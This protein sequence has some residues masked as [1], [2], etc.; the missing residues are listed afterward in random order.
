MATAGHSTTLPPLGGSDGRRVVGSRWSALALGTVASFALLVFMEWLFQVTKPSFLSAMSPGQKA[1]VLGAST[2]VAALWGCCALFPIQV[3]TWILRGERARK[4]ATAAARVPASLALGAL[5]F[6]LVDNFTYTVLGWGV[7]STS[8]FAQRSAYLMLLAGLLAGSYRLVGKWTR[9]ARR[10]ARAWSW[11][12]RLLPVACFAGTILLVGFGRGVG[13]AG[14]TV[15]AMIEPSRGPNILFFS[16]DGIDAGHM[17]AYGYERRTTP[18]IER[19]ASTS[20]IGENNFPNAAH[21]G[22]SIASILTGRLPT[23]T[24]LIFPPD[25]LK[26]EDAYRHLPAALKRLGYST[27][28]ITLRHYADAYDLNLR[29]GFDESNGRKQGTY[30]AAWRL[31]GSFGYATTYLMETMIDRLVSRLLHLTSRR[32]MSDAYSEVKLAGTERGNDDGR[33]QELESFLD[34]ARRPFFAHVHLMTTHGPMFSSPT[35][36]F[37][38]GLVQRED[39]DPNFFDDALLSVDGYFARI[40][41]KLRELGLWDETLIVVFSDHGMRFTTESRTPL[42]FRFPGGEHART[43]TSTTANLDIAPTVLDYLGSPVPD[44]MS[45]LSL[46]RSDP[47]RMRRVIS[48]KKTKVGGEA[49]T[50]GWRVD[51]RQ[52][53]PPFYA[54]GSVTTIVCQRAYRLDLDARRM[55]VDDLESHTAS[56]DPFELPG[57]EEVE[58]E[59]VDHLRANGYDVT[60]LDLPLPKRYP[61][62]RRRNR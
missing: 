54:L 4:L 7:Q 1:S 3:M 46:L 51:P 57:A 10:E 49:T 42:L 11:I 15:G 58:L 12:G 23:E 8:S 17:S 37:S 56:C 5:G 59:I 26:G 16:G 52:V 60:E 47:G 62:I 44:W 29:E 39:W 6:L 27:T 13:D 34:R 22:A 43:I 41:A 31:S 32:A 19:L 36:S 33:I 18:A 55:R 53:G 9:S 48:A 24:G 45:G 40:E 25:I 38:R 30:R 50:L 28:S 14:S 35:T 61:G 20:L 2:L 21:T